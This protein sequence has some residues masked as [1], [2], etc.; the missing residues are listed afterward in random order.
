MSLPRS[1]ELTARQKRGD[2]RHLAEWCVT[3]IDVNGKR[4]GRTGIEYYTGRHVRQAKQ[5]AADS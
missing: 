1:P 4:L 2:P 5:A 3:A